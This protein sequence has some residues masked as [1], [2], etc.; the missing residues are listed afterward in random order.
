MDLKKLDEQI[1]QEDVDLVE[2]NNLI[3]RGF[4]GRPWE[5]CP[6]LTSEI[7]ALV[8]EYLP[9]EKRK[10]LDRLLY[11]AFECGPVEGEEPYQAICLSQAEDLAWEFIQIKKALKDWLYLLI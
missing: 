8:R 6:P 10:D 4:D 11:G 1:I 9:E 3:Y 5:G 2:D 7:D